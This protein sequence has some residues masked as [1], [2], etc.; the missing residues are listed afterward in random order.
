MISEFDQSIVLHKIFGSQLK[1][2]CQAN[3]EIFNGKML[4]FTKLSLMSFIYELV[5]VFYFPV[6]KVIYIIYIYEK[7]MIERIYLYYVLADTDSTCIMFLFICKI[8]NSIPHNQFRDI[9]FKVI[10]STDIL[11][12]FDRSHEF[13]EKFN[14]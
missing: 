7:Y 10:V 12:R 11:N 3:F 2:R 5:E 9:I 8:R 13:Q 6:E 1:Q 14:V 4:M